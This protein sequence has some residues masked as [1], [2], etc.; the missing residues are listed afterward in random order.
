MQAMAKHGVVG[1][2]VLLDYYSWAHEHGREYDPFTS[3]K[4]SL[5]DLKSVAES[6]GVSFEIGDILLIRSGYTACYHKLE[7]ENPAKLLQAGVEL[8]A[9][10][11][12]EQT[13]EMKTWLHDKYVNIRVF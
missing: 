11:G 4:I 7:K 8:P 5:R 12:V 13:E 2:G 6:Q 10:A 1:R 3:H 9:L